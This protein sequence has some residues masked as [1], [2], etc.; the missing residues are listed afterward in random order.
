MGTAAHTVLF[1]LGE[2]DLSVKITE[3]RY[4]VDYQVQR[5]KIAQCK[6]VLERREGEQ[7]TCHN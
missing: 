2:G 7:Q 5:D 6:N 3:N 4:R 1:E